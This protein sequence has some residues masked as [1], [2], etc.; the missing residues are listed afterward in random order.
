MFD[1]Q[2]VVEV[3]NQFAPRNGREG[4]PTKILF[5]LNNIKIKLCVLW[6]KL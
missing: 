5:D 3:T 2:R 4:Q 1:P 6:P